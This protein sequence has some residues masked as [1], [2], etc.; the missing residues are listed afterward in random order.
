LGFNADG[1]LLHRTRLTLIWGVNAD[2]CLLHRTRLTLIRGRFQAVRLMRFTW[3]P[4]EGLGFGPKQFLHKPDNSRT[5]C[6]LPLVKFVT[7]WAAPL[8]ARAVRGALPVPTLNPLTQLCDRSPVRSCPHVV[9]HGFS[10]RSYQCQQDAHC[11]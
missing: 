1:C 9:L 8:Q 3:I 6:A 7:N 2:G 5:I 11:R 10:L 4:T